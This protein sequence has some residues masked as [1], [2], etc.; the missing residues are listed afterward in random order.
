MLDLVHL[1]QEADLLASKARNARCCDALR[2][3][4]PCVGLRMAVK[5]R[6]LVILAPR[7]HLRLV[8]SAVAG[9]FE[10]LTEAIAV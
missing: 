1:S 9:P 3:C 2:P 5:A 8:Q 6:R 4:R 7:R 10:G